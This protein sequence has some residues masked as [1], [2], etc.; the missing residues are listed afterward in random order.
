MGWQ[1]RLEIV[2]KATKQLSEFVQRVKREPFEH[3]LDEPVA[4]WTETEILDGEEIKAAVAIIRTRG[5]YWSIKEGCT[6][7]GYFN[8]TVPGGVETEFLE[9]QWIEI[10]NHFSN[11]KY[12]KIYTSGSFLD[13]TEIPKDFANMIMTDLVNYGIEKVLVESLPEFVH[14][15]HMQYDK[16]PKIEVAIGLESA[17]PIVLDK[18]VNKRLT[19]KGFKRACRVVHEIGGTVKAYILLKPPYLNEGQSIEDTI[20]SAKFAAP[21]VDKI[22]INPVN[23]QK[24]TVGE[25]MWRNREWK[26]P[27]LWSVVEVIEKCEKIG[28]RVY[29]DPTGGGTQRGA[30]NCGKCDSEILEN[31]KNSRINGTKIKKSKCECR[32]LWRNLVEQ[33]KYRRDGSEP[34]GYRRSF[35]GKFS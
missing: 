32:K 33:A 15:R 4:M 29:S 26:P 10:I 35:V 22:S 3:A 14:E 13:P 27:W 9:Q 12:V 5:C 19:E 16:S 2:P 8:D 23:I 31:L 34:E 11:Y 24:N 7:C 1:W 30:H 21:Y 25:R 20:Y 6:M 17:T 28:T 18:C